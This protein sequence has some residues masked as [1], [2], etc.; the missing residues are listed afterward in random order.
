MTRNEPRTESQI[1]LNNFQTDNGQAIDETELTNLATI[2]P[3]PPDGGYGW[4]CAL[5]VFLV[6]S[7][8][9]GINSVC[10]PSGFVRGYC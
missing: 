7:H 6:N 1:Q 5:S 8:T 10:F 9:W 4:V 2:E 3:I